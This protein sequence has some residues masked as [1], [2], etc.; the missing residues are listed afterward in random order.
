MQRLINIE[1]TSVCPAACR[2][3]PRDAVTDHGF[4]SIET[5][6]AVLEQLGECPSWELSIAGRGEPTIHPQFGQFVELAAG[7]GV[8][9]GVVT[10]G[11]GLGE[12]QIE[13]CSRHV[14]PVRLS[15]SSIDPE[16]FGMVHRRLNYEKVWTNI[17]A[18]ARA[19]SDKT[20]IHLVGGEVIY[21]RLPETV[22]ALRHH[23]R[24][25]GDHELA[26]RGK[27]V[28]IDDT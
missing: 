7:Q 19:A 3:C 26:E 5:L 17:R 13:A 15:V 10:T 4:M 23:P 8:P 24:E 25:L 12:A 14:N 20:V 1:A 18:L 2:M 9:V 6:G 28:G 11:V 22:E 27:D 21:P 16:I